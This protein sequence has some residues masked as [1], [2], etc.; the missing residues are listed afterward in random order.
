MTKGMPNQDEHRNVP[1]TTITPRDYYCMSPAGDPPFVV[2]V[3]VDEEH[4]DSALI[5]VDET[6]QQPNRWDH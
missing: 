3:L 5:H 4:N 6:L 1:W 2:D